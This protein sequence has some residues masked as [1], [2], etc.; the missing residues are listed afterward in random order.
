MDKPTR[1]IL[2]GVIMLVGAAL[3]VIFYWDFSLSNDELSALSRLNFNSFHDLMQQGVRV[4]GHPAGTQVLLYYLT[5]YF[6][7]SVAMVRL[8]FVLAGTLAIWYV[9]RIGR[10]WHSVS[11]GLLMAACFATLEFP[12]LY[13]RIAR[14]YGLGMLFATMAIYQWVRWYAVRMAPKI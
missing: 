2:L 10:A 8:P 3:R 12:L 13:S 7:D 11:A 9:Y 4:D 5:N 6:G 1:H 14:P